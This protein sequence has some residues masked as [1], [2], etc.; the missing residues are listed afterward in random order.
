[1]AQASGMW[2]KITDDIKM[3]INN[4]TRRRVVESVLDNGWIRVSSADPGESGSFD[5]KRLA[6]VT[7]SPQDHVMTQVL[8]GEEVAIGV[9]ATSD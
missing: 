2:R 5:I 8:G 4:R 3:Y 9:I 1:M 6:H 7:P